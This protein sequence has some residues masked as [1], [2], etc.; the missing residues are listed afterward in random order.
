MAFTGQ[1]FGYGDPNPSHTAEPF[2]RVLRS[3][4]CV[5]ACQRMALS[6]PDQGKT[7]KLHPAFQHRPVVNVSVRG[8]PQAASAPLRWL[9][10]LTAVA[11]LPHSPA[12]PPC[13]STDSACP[14]CPK[15]SVRVP[16]PPAHIRPGPPDEDAAPGFRA[17]QTSPG[18]LSQVW[19]EPRGG[20][21][22][23]GSRPPA[24]PPPLEASN[25]PLLVRCPLADDDLLARGP[26]Q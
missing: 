19:S 16:F 21:R 12:E 17:P 1:L 25:L 9:V 2:P 23:P 14:L 22:G 3:L 8:R 10:T 6:P 7:Q 4:R 26:A 13:V 15:C 5:Y 11:A 24:W 20:G 18:V